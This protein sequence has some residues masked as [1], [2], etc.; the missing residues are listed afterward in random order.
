MHR[1]IVIDN[2]NLPAAT[3]I[4]ERPLVRVI[5]QVDDIVVSHALW[6]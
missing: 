4:G 1:R 2:G 3:L 5:D 6:P